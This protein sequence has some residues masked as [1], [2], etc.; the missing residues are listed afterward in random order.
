VRFDGRILFLSQ[1]ASVIGRQLPGEDVTLEEAV[2]L[3][4]HISTDEITPAYICYYYY[5]ETLGEY[6][7][8]GLDC[9]RTR[10]VKQGSV[11]AGGFAVSVADPRYGKG[12]SREAS[13]A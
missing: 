2:P 9:A 8:L 10:R 11:K 3:R 12:S 6:S 13:A 4:T 1:N 7:Y 5:Y